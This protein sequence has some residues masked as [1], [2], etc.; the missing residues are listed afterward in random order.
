MAGG[1]PKIKNDRIDIIPLGNVDRAPIDYLALGLK[2]R[3]GRTVE[4]L[5]E[6][7]LPEETFDSTRNQWL[8]RGIL[9]SIEPRP[10]TWRTVAMSGEDLYAAGLS[11]V[12]GE[13]DPIGRRA[14]F[15]LHRLRPEHAG[16]PA[17]RELLFG[18]CLKEAVH[19][20]GHTLGLP[21]CRDRFCVMRF[22]NS[23]SDTDLKRD[24]FC[25]RCRRAAVRSITGGS[26]VGVGSGAPTGGG[27][28]SGR[29]GK[30][31]AAPA[32]K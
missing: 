3:F 6:Q 1:A 20:I 9:R 18:R 32:L 15:S 16:E 7:P 5:P 27:A 25:D 14:V 17:D 12:F 10:G 30:T 8:A 23:L 29:F 13:A 26:L 31:T 4:V 19:E 21:H 2:L 22:S 11:Y 28:R 24:H